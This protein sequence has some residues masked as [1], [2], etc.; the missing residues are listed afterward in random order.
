VERAD[1]SAPV[2]AIACTPLPRSP[3]TARGRLGSGP[4]SFGLAGRQSVTSKEWPFA[5]R[6]GN[7]QVQRVVH[8]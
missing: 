6:V 8:T 5:T 1:G 2:L 4:P 3:T 7:D